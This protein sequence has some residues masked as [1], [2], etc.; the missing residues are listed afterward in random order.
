MLVSEGIASVIG[1]ATE[2]DN[3]KIK[4]WSSQIADVCMKK[5]YSLGKPFKYT[6]K[7]W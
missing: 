3:V 6:R 1:E 7:Y 2:F 4:T 5:L